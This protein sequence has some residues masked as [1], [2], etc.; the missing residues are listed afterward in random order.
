MGGNALD[1]AEILERL[2]EHHEIGEGLE[3]L[4]ARLAELCESGLIARA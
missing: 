4:G 3:A 2:N 1:A